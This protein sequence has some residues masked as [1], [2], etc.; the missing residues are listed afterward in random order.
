MEKH[1]KRRMDEGTWK[2]EGGKGNMEEG[3]V[4]KGY[5]KKIF[6]YHKYLYPPICKALLML[7]I[8]L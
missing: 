3:R 6:K 8:S 2:K 4:A 1:G 7:N 5:W